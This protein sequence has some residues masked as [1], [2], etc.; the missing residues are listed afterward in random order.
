[1]ERNSHVTH[2]KVQD[3]H[4]E[5]PTFQRLLS[6]TR[7]QNLSVMF[8]NATDPFVDAV[9]ASR[10]ARSL[11]LDNNRLTDSGAKAL[12]A[13]LRQPDCPLSGISVW[14]NGEIRTAGLV[15][16]LDAVTTSRTLTAL[17]FNRLNDDCVD[18]LCTMLAANRSLKVLRTSVLAVGDAA[19]RMRVYE[20]IEANTTLLELELWGKRIA[21]EELTAVAKMIG[22]QR[23]LT[24][25]A[26]KAFRFVGAIGAIVPSV[27][28]NITLLELRL[29]DTFESQDAS[30]R[31][32]MPLIDAFINRNKV[33]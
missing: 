23:S 6:L 8:C 3:E 11:A 12:A 10:V 22:N 9:V 19:R 25:L 28:Q 2:L 20:A 24:Y 13:H 15:S 32:V 17:H 16:L 1:L 21:D 27:Q 7:L 29:A 18:A 30:F 26:T 33:Q 4:F 14:A 31:S 5:L